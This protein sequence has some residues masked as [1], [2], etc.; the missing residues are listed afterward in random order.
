MSAKPIEMRDRIPRPV[1]PWEK[2]EG[3]DPGPMKPDVDRPDTRDLLRRMRRVD[4]N[5]SR[6]YRQRTGE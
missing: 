6:R 1:D 2:R 4:P 3:D 5:Q